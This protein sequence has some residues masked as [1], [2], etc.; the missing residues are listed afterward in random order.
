MSTNSDIFGSII[1]AKINKYSTGN[2]VSEE[3]KVVTVSDGIVVAFFFRNYH[4][5]RMNEKCKDVLI[6]FGDLSK[7]AVSY[8]TIS[9]LLKDHQDVKLILVIYS[10]YIHIYLNMLAELIKKGVNTINNSFNNV[11]NLTLFDNDNYYKNNELQINEEQ[12]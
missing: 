8:H 12:Y 7:H 4:C 6:I 11:N 5:W 9:L 2:V 1:K 3:G 10:I